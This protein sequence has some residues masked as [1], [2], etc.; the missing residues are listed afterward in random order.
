MTAGP[1]KGKAAN[2]F[3][4]K[5]P[6]PAIR[7]RFFLAKYVLRKSRQENVTFRQ[8]NVASKHGG[9]EPAPF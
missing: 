6:L 8:D 9:Q 2:F 5:I 4:G 1:L 3:I 7:R